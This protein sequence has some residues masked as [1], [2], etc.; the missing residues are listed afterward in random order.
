MTI[1]SLSRV[2]YKYSSYMQNDIDVTLVRNYKTDSR[3][4]KISFRKCYDVSFGNII[5]CFAL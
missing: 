5:M 4:K 2:S 3:M 1:N